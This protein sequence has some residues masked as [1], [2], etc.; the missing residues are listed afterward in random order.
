MSLEE[1]IKGLEEGIASA[2]P[3]LHQAED[4]LRAVQQWLAVADLAI[5]PFAL[6][7]FL[8]KS[9][10][11][12]ELL[13]ALIRYLLTKQPHA[14]SDRDKLDYLLT[15]YFALGGPQEESLARE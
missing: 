2:E 15:A 12:P 4:N 11:E 14:E 6:R 7:T 13:R 1:R 10:P 3:R 9:R 8:E 5:S